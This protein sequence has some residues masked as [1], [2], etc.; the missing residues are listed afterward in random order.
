MIHRSDILTG[1]P[2]YDWKIEGHP[3][4]LTTWSDGRSD[5]EHRLLIPICFVFKQIFQ[6]DVIRTT[7]SSCPGFKL[8]IQQVLHPVIHVDLRVL[9]LLSLED[10]HRGIQGFKDTGRGFRV[11]FPTSQPDIRLVVTVLLLHVKNWFWCRTGKRERESDMWNPDQEK[12]LTFCRSKNLF[13]SVDRITQS[14]HSSESS[15]FN[16]HQFFMVAILLFPVLEFYWV[17]TSR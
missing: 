2:D 9:H 7:R 8:Q 10:T 12:N 17:R 14:F 6:E 1:R 5:Q 3:F 13:L 16:E 4:R 15:Y 11:T